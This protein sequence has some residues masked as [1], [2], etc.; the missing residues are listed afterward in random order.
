MRTPQVIELITRYAIASIEK[1]AED[2]SIYRME[3]VQGNAL[4][5]KPGQ[6]VFLHILDEQ[7]KTVVKRPYSIASRPGVPYLEFCIKIVGGE[8]TGRLEKMEKGS[9]VGIEGPFGDFN[10]EGQTNA[11][12]VAG[13]VGLAPFMSMLRHIAEKKLEGRFILF[14]STRRLDTMIY[15]EELAQLEKDNPGIKVVI[16]LTREKPPGWAGECG[17]IG[18][19]MLGRHAGSLSEFHWWIC[20]R[21]AMIKAIRECLIEKGLDPKRIKVEGWG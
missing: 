18:E 19:E 14:Y 10:F 4:M 2:I 13:G 11:T 15:R 17:R 5:F 16:T 21:M 7:G 20:G 12:F 6:F 8:L 9:V 1:H 3:P